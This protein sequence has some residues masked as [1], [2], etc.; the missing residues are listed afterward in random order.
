MGDISC[1]EQALSCHARVLGKDEAY[2]ANNVD[3]AVAGIRRAQ[4]QGMNEAAQLPGQF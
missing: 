2:I 1:F 4:L 3:E